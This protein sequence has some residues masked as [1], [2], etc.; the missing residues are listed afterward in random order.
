MQEYK[1][2][3]FYIFFVCTLLLHSFHCIVLGLP[4]CVLFFQCHTLYHCMHHFKCWQCTVNSYR[5]LGKP[6]FVAKYTMPWR[7]CWCLTLSS[8]TTG[9][10]QFLCLTAWLRI[11]FFYTEL[12]EEVWLP[13]VLVNGVYWTQLSVT[14]MSF[15]WRAKCNCITCEEYAS[16][17]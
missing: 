6:S 15:T 16:K 11:R 10:E 4:V 14:S 17:F 8:S 2:N 1:P 12:C 13:T 9:D 5:R 3:V 7:C